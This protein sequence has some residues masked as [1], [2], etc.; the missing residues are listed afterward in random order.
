MNYLEF[1][2]YCESMFDFIFST[3]T[4]YKQ[5]EQEENIIFNMPVTMI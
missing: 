1:K 5:E 4:Q 3:I 2:E